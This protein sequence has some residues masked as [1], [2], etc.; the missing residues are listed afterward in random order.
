[1][2]SSGKFQFPYANMACGIT[3]YAIQI[4]KTFLTRIILFLCPFS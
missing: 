4:K 3:D 2:I 1:M